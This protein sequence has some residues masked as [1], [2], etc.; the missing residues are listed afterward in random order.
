LQTL[1][2]PGNENSRELKFLE[3]SL[4]G[5]KVPGNRVPENDRDTERKLK[6][7]VLLE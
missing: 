4:L 2:F 6:E 3:L 5:G 7:F 1:S